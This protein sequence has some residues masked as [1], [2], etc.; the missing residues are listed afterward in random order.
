MGGTTPETD[1]NDKKEGEI[2]LFK[3]LYTVSPTYRMPSRT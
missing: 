3:D 1:E 2:P